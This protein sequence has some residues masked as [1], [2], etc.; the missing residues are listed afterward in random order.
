MLKEDRGAT[1]YDSGRVM[2]I[3]INP[4]EARR[5]EKIHDWVGAIWLPILVRVIHDNCPTRLHNIP[6]KSTGLHSIH[7]IDDNY[8]KGQIPQTGL[9][10]R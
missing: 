4:E 6:C 7:S 8:I 3:E 5:T 1:W 2:A 10:S 9:N